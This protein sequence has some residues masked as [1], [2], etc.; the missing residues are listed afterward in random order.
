MKAEDQARH[1]DLERQAAALGRVRAALRAVA[2]LSHDDLDLLDALGD[3]VTG[4]IRSAMKASTAALR[5]GDGADA[6]LAAELR[7]I[8][9]G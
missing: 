2:G 9:E 6:E 1:A 4:P 5:A 7:R 3:G 8:E